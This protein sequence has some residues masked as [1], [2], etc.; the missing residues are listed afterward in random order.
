[1]K[2]IYIFPAYFATSA[3][4][5]GLV[6]SFFEGVIVIDSGSDRGELSADL[7]GVESDERMG[8]VL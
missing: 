3:K 8:D 1:M 7:L 6:V 2:N 4:E 5:L